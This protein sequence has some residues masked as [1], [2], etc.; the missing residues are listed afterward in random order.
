M[1]KE[2]CSRDFGRCWSTRCKPAK[3]PINPTLKLSKHE[4]DVLNDTSQYRKL[5][6]RLL[7]LTITRL[8][9]TFAIHKLSQFMAKP[10]KPHYAA[11]L[12]VLHY[13][14]SEPRKGVFF[15][16]K[17]K[18]H[19]K[20]FSDA[21][22]ASCPDTRR[23]VTGYCIFLGDLL[24]SWKSKKQATIS[25][26]SGEV[27]Y[28]AMAVATCEIMWILYLLRDLQIRHDREAMLFCDNQSTLHIGSNPI[29]HERTKHIKIDCH[30]V[31]DKVL[32]KVI[33]L[34]HVRTHCQLADLL[35]KALGRKQFSYLTSKMG[36]LNIYSSLVHL[37]GEY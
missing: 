31:R 25:R 35:T 1:S 34:N 26:S 11:A 22:W 21:N 12:K 9:I 19:V 28:R 3:V 6:G 14:K 8:D 15:S 24:I 23:S 20:G 2:I 29:F 33:K 4:G 36:L 27:E 13:L 5:V 37:E 30:I 32:A 10:R 17:S 16:A 7:Y 18:L